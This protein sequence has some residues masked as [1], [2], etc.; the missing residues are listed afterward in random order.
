[1]S[2]RPAIQEHG[3]LK[4]CRFLYGAVTFLILLLGIATLLPWWQQLQRYHEEIDDRLFNIERLQ[5]IVAQ[6]TPLL[7]A[8]EQLQASQGGLSQTLSGQTEALAAAELQQLL[9]SALER[10]KGELINTQI[11]QYPAAEEEPY[12]K[13]VLRV[14]LRLATDRIAALLYQLESGRPLL[15]I[16]NLTLNRSGSSDGVAAVMFNFDLAGYI[17]RGAS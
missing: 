14:Q 12:Q 8:I 17:D 5:R 1:M 11:I 13:V 9:K 16:D 2:Q 15:F 3:K 7:G 4:R 6:T 10:V